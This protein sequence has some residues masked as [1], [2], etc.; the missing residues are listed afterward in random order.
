[1]DRLISEDKVIRA[2][3]AEHDRAG[4]LRGY[5]DAI[6]AIPSAEPCEDAIS[7]EVILLE[8]DKIKD[9]YGGLLDVAMFIRGL[10]SVNP[11]P[12]TDTLDKIRA[13]IPRLSHWQTDDGQDLLM[14]ADALECIDK[15]TGK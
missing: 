10:P 13:E 15:H 14:V 12:K 5:L 9:N 3:Y 8:I 2:I 1:M 4:T 6:K 7:R 11:Q